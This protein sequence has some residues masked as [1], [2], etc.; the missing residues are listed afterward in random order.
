MTAGRPPKPLERKQK[1]AKGDHQTPGHRSPEAPSSG[2]VVAIPSLGANTPQNRSQTLPGAPEGLE[3]RGT[4]EWEKIWTA[5]RQWLHR[6]EDYHWV[7]QIAFAYDAIDEMRRSVKAKGLYVKGY[8][9]QA[10]ANPLLK[11]IR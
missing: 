9:G 11:E 1:L 6:E 2:K 8:N 5:G 3:E 4:L 10:A 7:E